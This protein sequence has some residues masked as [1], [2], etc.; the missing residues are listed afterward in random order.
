MRIRGATLE[1]AEPVSRIV[2]L[3]YEGFGHTDGFPGDVIAELRECRGSAGCIWEL[4]T[5]EDVFVADD[6]GGVRGVVSVK[7]NEIT[8]LFIDPSCQGQGIG[9]ELFVRA[10]SSIR[11]HGHQDMFLS[12]AVRTPLPFYERMGMRIARERTIDC[13][14]CIGMM[15]TVLEKALGA[16]GPG[17]PGPPEA[18]DRAAP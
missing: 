6:E 4:I 17:A 7:T 5:D 1:D 3:C 14:P 8:K 9:R 16:A 10:E 2:C 12:A 11:D 13:G 18:R 15:S